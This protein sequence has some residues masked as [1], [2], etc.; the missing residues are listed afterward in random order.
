M[1]ESAPA[2]VAT[3]IEA[4]NPNDPDA[5]LAMV[6]EGAVVDDWGGEFAG[7]DVIRGADGF[8]GPSRFSVL[9]DGVRRRPG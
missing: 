3:L 1:L 6:V 7:T 5:F 8:N 2:P 4:V 9:I